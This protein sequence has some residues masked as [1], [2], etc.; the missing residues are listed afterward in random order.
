MAKKSLIIQVDE[1]DL[2]K[3]KKIQVEYKEKGKTACALFREML[4]KFVE[5]EE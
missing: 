4:E 5:G 3:F 2:K 1:N